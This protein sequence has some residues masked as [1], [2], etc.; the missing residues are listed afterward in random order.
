M[1]GALLM[2]NVFLTLLQFVL[3]LV[4]FAAFSF[5]PLMNLQPATF[6]WPRWLSKKPS[7]LWNTSAT[8]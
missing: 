5:L 4:I 7:V 6:K 8:W 2:K 3:F 1:S